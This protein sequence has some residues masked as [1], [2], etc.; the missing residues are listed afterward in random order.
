MEA[1]MSKNTAIKWALTYLVPIV[2]L[3]VPSNDIFT[4]K[5][6]LF[7]AI[8]VCAMMLMAFEFFNTYVVGMLLPAVYL[9]T[10]LAD[11][12]TVMSPWMGTTCYMVLGAFTLAAILQE[13]G[14][15]TRIAYWMMSK[16]GGNYFKVLLSIF[17]AGWVL[18][19]LT[20]GASAHIILPALC[21]GLIYALDISGT[22]AAA[23][24]AMACMIGSC[25]S[26]SFSYPAVTYGVI[27]GL[28]GETLGAGYQVSFIDAFLY[29]WPMALFSLLMLWIMSK[30]YKND[31]PLSSREY[32]QEKLKELGPIT[33]NEK[34][35]SVVLILVIAFLLTNPFHGFE[36][37]Y[38]FMLIPYLV[39]VIPSLNSATADGALNVPWGMVFV[40]TGCMS[41]GVV[42]SNL[43]IGTLIQEYVLPI[44]EANN[45]PFFFFAAL[46]I[47]VFIA[48]LLMTP[49]AI[50][51][52]VTIPLIEIANAI[53]YDPLSIIFGLIHTCELVIFPYEYTTYLIVYAFGMMSM[54]DF[55]VTNTVRC[56]ITGIGFVVVLVP[57]WMLLGLI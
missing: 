30:W 44:L 37:A 4:W 56:L 21:I 24:I 31:K 34:I 40:M 2:I 50:W 41:I 43:G 15:L 45:N 53:G 25:A 42:A 35:N 36:V 47:F 22:K 12:N 10:G 13:C 23:G 8:T 27:T 32:F 19:M 26:R 28:A 9:I 17:V 51:A 55:I 57:Y 52:L 16:I 33:R 29:N 48:N 18:T 49:M 1:K 14:L 20:F 5:I 54:K 46:L 3:L 38:G 7:L 11:I 6:K 39:W